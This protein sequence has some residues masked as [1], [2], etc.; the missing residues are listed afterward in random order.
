MGWV[1]AANVLLLLLLGGLALGLGRL[2]P[3]RDR[4]APPLIVSL[5]IG[6]AILLMLG[7]LAAWQMHGVAA[8]AGTLTSTLVGSDATQGPLAVGLVLGAAFPLLL[9]LTS[10][11]KALVKRLPLSV[12]LVEGF[13]DVAPPL[14]CAL[15]LLYGGLTLWTVHEE[16]AVNRGLERAVHGEGQALA[17]QEGKTWPGVVR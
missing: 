3:I 12:G 6:L 5:G 1:L 11:I 2:S 10:S 16:S 13:R 14:G 17:A 9:L 7:G 15:A 4:I 8:L